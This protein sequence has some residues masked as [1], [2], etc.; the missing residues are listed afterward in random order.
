MLQNWSFL[1][2]LNFTKIVGKGRNIVEFKLVDGD[3][4]GD[5]GSGDEGDGDEDDGDEDD[6]DEGCG[7]ENGDEEKDQIEGITS[8]KI[9]D[10]IETEALI[11]EFKSKNK[12]GY[13]LFVNLFCDN[14]SIPIAINNPIFFFY[15]LYFQNNNHITFCVHSINDIINKRIQFNLQHINS[16]ILFPLTSRSAERNFSDWRRIMTLN[17]QTTCLTMFVLIF[18]RCFS[19]ESILTSLNNILY[20]LNA[21]KFIEYLKYE[22]PLNIRHN[23]LM[24]K[25]IIQTQTNQKKTTKHKIFHHLK[26]IYNLSHSNWNRSFSVEFLKI[27][28]VSAGN[29]SADELQNLILD[30]VPICC[31]SVHEESDL[32]NFINSNLLL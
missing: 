22:Y 1:Y 30:C 2:G 27:F 10:S 3:V 17:P 31:L 19:Y 28:D 14:N 11:T 26:S 21:Q 24:Q 6:C 8:L 23:F 20:D 16:N 9:D 18:L 29:K 4:S 13:E 12:Y 7:D 5:E 32:S 25:S 15:E